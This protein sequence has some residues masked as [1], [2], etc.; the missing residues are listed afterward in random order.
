LPFRATPSLG[1]DSK[2]AESWAVDASIYI[3]L[4]I[5]RRPEADWGMVGKPICPPGSPSGMVPT[6][7]ILRVCTQTASLQVLFFFSSS[8]SEAKREKRICSEVW[9]W[10][11]L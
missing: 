11:F 1:T 10:T 5:R 8:H 6:N 9:V 7:K 2:L 4:P 3:P